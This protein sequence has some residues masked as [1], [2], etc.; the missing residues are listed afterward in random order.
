M[1]RTF[2]VNLRTQYAKKEVWIL[3][4][5][6]LFIGFIF[7]YRDLRVDYGQGIENL[8]LYVVLG[9]F[10]LLAFS[11]IQKVAS[12]FIGVKAEVQMSFIGI[13]ISVII[14][15]LFSG[16]LFFFISP[17]FILRGK[18]ARPGAKYI[19]KTWANFLEVAFAGTFFLLLLGLLFSTTNNIALFDSFG[20]LL[21]YIV[22]FSLIPFDLILSY[23]DRDFGATAG[24]AII[25]KNFT[26]YV[27]ILVF[28]IVALAMSYSSAFILSIVFGILAAINRVRPETHSF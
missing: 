11:Y 19:H 21:I 20:R 27:F 18:Q 13:I 12:N 23:F 3:F 14:A 7:S 24:T 5:Y 15:V 2:V 10:G 26:A 8:V 6:A 25:Y 9:F 16:L 1:T 22:L 17:G 4:W 28:T